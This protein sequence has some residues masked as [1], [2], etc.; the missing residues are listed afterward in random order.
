MGFRVL[1]VGGSGAFGSRL[2]ERLAATTDCEIVIAGRTAA[3]LDA[4][5][6]KLRSAYPARAIEGA[7]LDKNTVPP[8]RL[9]AL[10]LNVVVDAAGPYQRAEPALARTAIAA[11]INYVDLADARDF[12][13]EFSKLDADAKAAGVVAVTGASS[14]PALSNAVLDRLTA[15][16]Q[17]V[18][19]VA[20]AISPGNRAQPGLSVV[21]AILS[22]AGQPVSVW[23]DGRWMAHEGWG[24]LVREDMPNV[25]RRWLSLCETPDLDIVPKRFP[26]VRRAIFRAGVELD[27]FHLGLWFL[28]FAVRWRIVRSLKPFA[29]LFHDVYDAFSAFGS[30]RG[31]MTVKVEGVDAHGTPMRARWSLSAQTDGP[32]VPIVPALALIRHWR[33]RGFGE[34]GAMACAGL[35]DLATLER[36]LARLRIRTRTDQWPAVDA[37]VLAQAMGVGFDTVPSLVRHIHSP[38]PKV[39]L[40]GR[41]DI[42]GNETWLGGWIAWLAGFPPSAKNLPATVTIERTGQEEIWTRRFGDT[43][44]ASRMSAAVYGGLTETFGLISMLL[45]PLPT[46]R[47]FTLAVKGWRLGLIPLPAFL[48]PSTRANAGMDDEGRYTFDVWIGMPLI[49]RLVHYRGWLTET[50]VQPSAADAMTNNLPHEPRAKSEAPV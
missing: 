3:K 29:R 34:P 24:D 8:D 45:E 38:A 31:G 17:R 50:V 33:E 47:G 44:F 18:D 39:R 15:E 42:D 40:D 5:I 16:W 48:M 30:E 14:T 26:T 25:G 21:E 19:D 10:N 41:V 22:Y 11:G 2:V 32:N 7:V 1:V 6:A 46:Q 20:I 37:P 13:S 28:S 12:V 4:H 36:E 35:L 49:G 9:R 43:A 23:D 27:V